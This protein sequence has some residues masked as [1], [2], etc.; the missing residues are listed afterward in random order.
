MQTALLKKYLA[1]KI[2]EV[3]DEAIL[4]AIKTIVEQHLSP[5]SATEPDEIK[6][7]A[8]EVREEEKGQEIEEWLKKL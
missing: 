3:Q 5:P 4:L 7:L 2:Q 8:A 1:D 6:Q